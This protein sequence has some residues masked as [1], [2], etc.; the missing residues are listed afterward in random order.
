MKPEPAGS[1]PVTG[2]TRGFLADTNYDARGA[3]LLDRALA[4]REGRRPRA[5]GAMALHIYEVMTGM[6]DS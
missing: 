5:S 1:G 3:G 6:L 2:K 4:V